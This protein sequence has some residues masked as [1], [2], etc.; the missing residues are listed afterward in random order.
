MLAMAI[1]LEKKAFDN[2]SKGT[3][4]EDLPHGCSIVSYD[5]LAP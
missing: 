3:F 4:E 1:F 2:A 5:K